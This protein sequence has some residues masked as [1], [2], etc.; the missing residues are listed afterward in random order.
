MGRSG[1]IEGDTKPNLI[2]DTGVIVKWDHATMD[3]GISGSNPDGSTG[4]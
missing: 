1:A 4:R 3:C 2:E